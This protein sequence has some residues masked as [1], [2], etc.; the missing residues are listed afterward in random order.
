MYGS[1][2]RF[3]RRRG[4]TLIE[5]LVV[6]AIIA[7][8]IAL[9]LPAVQTAR[10]AARRAQ[11]QNSLKQLGL[12]LH[13]YHG[14]YGAFVYLSGGTCCASNATSNNGRLSGFIALLPYIEQRPMYQQIMAGSATV[15]P[16]G[17]WPHWGWGP[18]NN[19]PD[20]LLCPSDDGYPNMSA[21]NHSYV[22]C[23]GD[24]INNIISDTNPRGI[25]G[26]NNTVRIAR[27]V[28]GTSNTI[29]M[30]EIVGQQAGGVGD[31]GSPTTSVAQSVEDVKA[32]ASGIS[33]II[34]SPLACQ[35]TSNGT[36]FLA[37]QSLNSRRGV[38]W[39]FGNPSYVGFNT[40][41]P[42]NSPSCTSGSSGWGWDAGQIL[43]PSSRHPG[44]VN[45]LFADGSVRFISQNINTGNLGVA[46][47]VNGMSRYGVWGALG[48]KNGGEATQ[49]P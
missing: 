9:L 21:R 43:P 31:T 17:K 23:V 37:G 22:F 14:T 5:L 3:R 29:A 4:F 20:M 10:E 41:L 6:I 15:P 11:C 19:A 30:S 25:F 35:A 7:V 36:Y 49:A 13:N 32:I 38:K 33:S 48:S 46:Q 18:W 45:C 44:G 1:N 16:G 12:A 8:L 40:V 24:Q 2:F 28:D 39:T 42:P 47:P 26:H 27:I 34:T